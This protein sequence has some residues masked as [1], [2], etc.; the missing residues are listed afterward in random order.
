MYNQGN[1]FGEQYTCQLL[2]WLAFS[3]SAVVTY[4]YYWLVVVV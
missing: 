2:D 1:Y 4:Y 3:C